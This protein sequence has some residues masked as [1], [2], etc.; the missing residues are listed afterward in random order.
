MKARVLRDKVV[1]L[2]IIVPV[3]LGWFS[4]CGGDEKHAKTIAYQLCKTCFLLIGDVQQ[5][6]PPLEQ[7]EWRKRRSW[8]AGLNFQGLSAPEKE[9]LEAFRSAL[10]DFIDCHPKGSQTLLYK[11]S[12][13]IFKCEPI[14]VDFEITGD[15]ARKDGYPADLAR[16]IDALLDLCKASFLMDWGVNIEELEKVRPAARYF[17]E[18]HLVFNCYASW[19]GKTSTGSGCRAG[20][21]AGPN[22]EP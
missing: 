15:A 7:S 17:V 12:E 2:V 11:V 16:R 19:W 14:L 10:L 6:T 9:D 13:L 8:L 3:I 21:A 18:H 1:A 20:H 22:R 4:G 5:G